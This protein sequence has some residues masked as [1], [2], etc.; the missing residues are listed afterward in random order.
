VHQLNYATAPF[1]GFLTGYV[2][3]LAV[4]PFEVVKVRMQSKE[5]LQRYNSSAHCAQTMV[6]DQV[7]ACVSVSK[8]C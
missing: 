2:E 4:T 7:P 5:H 6:C 8:V 3:A 1:A